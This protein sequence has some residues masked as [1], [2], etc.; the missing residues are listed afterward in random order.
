MSGLKH[1]GVDRHRLEWE[2]ADLE[3]AFANTWEYENIKRPGINYGHGIL[4]DL[5]FNQRSRE[6]GWLID[7]EYWISQRE[8]TIVATVIQWLGTNCG[9]A[10]LHTA[11]K[12]AGWTVQKVEPERKYTKPKLPDPEI[13]LIRIEKNRIRA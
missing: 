1:R 3:R 7:V 12:K 2:H 6:E 8:A 4:Q 11:L 10:F 13:R 5:M 9:M